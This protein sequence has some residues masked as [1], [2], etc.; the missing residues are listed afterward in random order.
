[1]ISLLSCTSGGRSSGD[2]QEL[3][4]GLG[5]NPESLDPHQARGTPED[6]VILNLFEGLTEY[7]PET[8]EPM[9]ALAERWESNQDATQ[10]TFYLRQDARW[11]NGDPVTAH[12]FVYSWRRILDPRTASPYASMLYPIRQ[13]EGFNRGKA[14]D[15]GVE[16][17]DD[18]TLR[19]HMERPTAFFVQMT[20]HSAFRPVHRPTVERWNREWTKAEHLVVNG[21]YK[22]LE[23]LPNDKLVL[24]KNPAYREAARVRIERATFYLAED[25]N[26]LLNL[27][28]TGEIDT[29]VSG[30]L[31]TPSIPLLRKKSDYVT[32]PYLSLYYYMLNVTRPPFDNKKVR[33]ALNLSLDRQQICDKL[34]QAGQRPARTLTPSDFGGAYPRPQGVQYDPSQAKQFMR[35]A[36][37]SDGQ[38]LRFR[39]TFNTAELHR[40]LA[41]AIQAQWTEVFPRIQI[42]LVNLE[43][44]VYLATMRQMDYEMIRRYWTADYNDP[45]TFLELMLSGSSNNYTGWANAAYDQMVVQANAS[46]D[47]VER[48]KLLAQAEGLALEDAPFIPLYEGV[49]YFLT[50]PYVRGWHSNILDRHPLKFVW[51]E[52]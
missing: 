19:V 45:F 51:L 49:T 2:I 30:L 22:L 1:L 41:E 34:L 9:P 35:E 23:W 25:F 15:I 3:R 31:P 6:Q 33:L 43:W 4:I 40:Q 5:A 48:L 18:Y 36:G 50:K 7:N 14:R 12:D 26:A 44:Q 8:A 37:Y 11:S 29:L 52:R 42:E 47:P 32:G 38:G 24:Q 10:Y 27:Y 46:V 20:P 16:A 28:Q 21:P 39:I 13:A 17:V